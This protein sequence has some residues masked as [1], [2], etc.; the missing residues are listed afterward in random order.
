MEPSV[1]P[2]TLYGGTMKKK[3][4]RPSARTKRTARDREIARFQAISTDSHDE[5]ARFATMPIAEVDARLAALNVNA[6]EIVVAVQKLIHEKLEEWARRRLVH[7][8]FLVIL[9]AAQRGRGL[10]AACLSG[11]AAHL[12]RLVAYI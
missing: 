1:K 2:S 3:A 5:I 10:V 12:T 7:M 11:P 4:K 6:D 9:I 8:I